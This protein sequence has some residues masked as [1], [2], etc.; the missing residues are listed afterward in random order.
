ME[1]LWQDL[2]YAVRM[3]AKKPGFTA[4][5]VLTL[6]L[7][8]GANTAIFSVVNTVLLRALPFPHPERLVMLWEKDKDGTTNNTSFATYVDWRN[9]SHS[10]E[11][12]A[13]ISYWF[14][15]IVGQDHAEKLEGLRVSTSFFSVLGVKP[16]IGRDFETREDERGNHHV[17]ILSHGLWARKFGSDPGIAGK[18]ITM[19]GVVY[20][21]VG[22][23][24]E[25]FE[26]LFSTNRERPAEIWA[27]L[28]YNATLPWACRTCRHLRAVARLNAGVSLAQAGAEMNT[29]SHDLFVQYPHDYSAEGVVMTPLHEQLV[30]DVRPAL[31]ALL[32]AVGFVL[33]IACGNVANL[34]LGL[35]AQ[36]RREVAIRSAL[37]SSRWRLIRQLLT[38]SVLLA[39]LGGA[40]GLLFAV[41]GVDFLVSLAPS[42]L[43]R[44]DQIHLD[45]QVLAY[46]LGLCL[47]TGVIFGMA[48]ALQIFRL[49]P[50]ESLKEG[51]RQMGASERRPL[52]SA[53]VVSGVALALMLLIGSG[54]M[55]RSVSKLL[56]VNPGFDSEKL[57]TME[58]DFTGSGY[59]EDVPCAA[60]PCL[61]AQNF[62]RQALERIQTLP[63]VE[64]A[65]VVSQLPLGGNM[66][67]YGMHVEG[68]L[69]PNPED[70]PSADRY[71]VSL[72]Y[73]RAMRIPVLRGRSFNEQD[74]ADSPAVALISETF[75]RR[76]WSHE[77]PLGHR[78]KMGDP[79]GPWRTIVGVVGDVRHTG[80]DAPS[81][82][83]I[84]LPHSQWLDS[85]T[86]LAVR[87]KGDPGSLAGAVRDAIWSVDKNQPISKVATMDRVIATSMAQRR[88]AMTLF[89]IFAG[90]ALV[91]AAVG[92]YGVLAHNVSTRTNE[93][94]VR[95][96]LGAQKGDILRLVVR[97]GLL[98]TAMGI[99]IG[100][101][102]AL[103]LTRFL[104]SQLFGVTP[105]DPVT[106][107]GV[108]MLLAAVALLACYIP[109][110]RAT[111]VDPMVALR[112]E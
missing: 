60:G 61:A 23:M 17:V 30:G 103:A 33:L 9:Q 7:G 53:L 31:F 78:I 15:T 36:R 47:L 85:S 67:R 3:L 44:L 77:D 65:G 18:P 112:Y 80:L 13:A 12:V 95:I 57:L 74:R 26:S 97:Q 73:L 41:W 34:L 75:A 8:I 107:A 109:A 21:V 28:A 6:A 14:P 79:Q 92:L 52:R 32:G 90:L 104:A 49:D 45:S 50:N 16:A 111:R 68:K 98:L 72:D 20:V 46:T 37:G 69:S 96:A 10:L 48:P 5:A 102:G 38:E 27:P 66:D 87:T 83:Q 11:H 62:Y 110:R 89:S 100:V 86:V 42:N 29:I 91:L 22:V 43:P 106:F 35:A 101:A 94:G 39:M 108:P 93:L 99:A 51:G 58:V 55:L 63:G 2:R 59:R 56:A 19:D 54:L 40:A 25:G 76:I 1:T 24:P 88:F 64:A 70:D 105:T 71:A 84:Y 4:I 82:M 81:A